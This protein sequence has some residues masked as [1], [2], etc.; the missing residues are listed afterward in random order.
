MLKG[1]VE[2]TIKE[3]ALAAGENI[4][5]ICMG[6][7]DKINFV[8]ASP[9]YDPNEFIKGLKSKGSID[10][11]IGFSTRA[12]LTT[13]GCVVNEEGFAGLLS[14]EDEN[15]VVGIAAS[16][17]KGSAR[18][19][20][21]KVA[22]EALKN[23]KMDFAPDY[24]FMTASAE[25]EQYL[26]GIQDV[27]GRIPCFGGSPSSGNNYY[28]YCKDEAISNGVAVAFFYTDKEINTKYSAMYSETKRVGVVTKV[29]DNNLLVEINGQAAFDV[30]AKM[31][32]KK[33]EEIRENILETYIFNPL[34]I[35]DR[36]GDLASLRSLI[37]VG[38][39][40]SMLMGSQVAENT[41][42]VLMD[43]KKE[44]M[45]ND[46]ETIMKFLKGTVSKPG[47]YLLLTNEARSFALAE[48]RNELLSK[49]KSAVADVAFIMPMTKAE[50][51]YTDD[52][53]NSIGNLMMSF[54]VF[55]E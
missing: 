13:D 46:T 29:N 18:D 38:E 35:K 21:R 28:I 17:K 8:F 34:A 49:V 11:L 22:K 47:S 41:A 6:D 39:D 9:N 50:Y 2:I 55:E 1:K 25:E 16:E 51:G 12:I 43:K 5:K 52:Q 37:S 44:E 19:T 53:T 20:A 27:I 10:N 40:G 45:L 3:T 26:K 15:L 24:F 48:Q 32:N 42:V 7:S 23:S 31:L 4:A 33:P 54:T 14:I 36:L 30:Y